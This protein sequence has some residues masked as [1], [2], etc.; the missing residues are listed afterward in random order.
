MFAVEIS[1]AGCSVHSGRG[2]HRVSCVLV[3]SFAFVR[4]HDLFVRVRCGA[5]RGGSGSVLE[6]SCVRGRD[7]CCV[8]IGALW[9][10]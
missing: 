6:G 2:A 1:A 7:R 9:A 5:R 3:L 10:S 4:V 8:L